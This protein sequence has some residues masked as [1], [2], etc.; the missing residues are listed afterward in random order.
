LSEIEQGL[1]LSLMGILITFAS[2]GLLIVVMILLRELFNP[3]R[4]DV[5]DESPAKEAQLNLQSVDSDREAA[6][7]RAAGIAVAV[8]YLTSQR[9]RGANLGQLLETPPGHWWSA[10]K[11]SQNE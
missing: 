2:L 3:K 4:E 1:Q 10:S 8:A 11:R 5:A 9:K 6:R 7:Q